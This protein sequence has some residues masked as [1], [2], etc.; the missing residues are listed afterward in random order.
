[1]VE[2]GIP[3]LHALGILALQ[4]GSKPLQDAIKTLSAAINEGASFY[5]A[6]SKAP[7]MFDSTFV[8]LV[9]AGEESGA[10]PE[11]LHMLANHADTSDKTRREIRAAMIYPACVIVC[12]A[13]MSSLLLIFVIPSLKE[14]FSDGDFS[15]PWLT[16]VVMSISDGVIDNGIELCGIACVALLILWR[17]VGTEL[18]KRT[19]RFITF[20]TPYVEKLVKQA[21]AL[22]VI[23]T[24]GIT[25]RVGIPIATALRISAGASGNA[26]VA[27]ELEITRSRVINGS[28][29]SDALSGSLFL[30][31]SVIQMLRVG[32]M[33]GSLDT[34]L[35]TIARHSEGELG[36]ARTVL[37][38]LLEPALIVALGLIIGTLVVATYLPL[39]SMG[40]LF[41][42]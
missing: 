29:L 11:T 33:T 18:G 22:R 2:V 38:N 35:K 37:K 25:L 27:R 23:T 30:A 28:P 8:H 15:L 6:M 34:I 36:Q 31:P 32:E 42:R 24:L 14:I 4:P 39:F 9:Q 41:T 12:A 10:L 13:F 17:F 7:W 1:M 40:N 3:P 19:T 21:I 20:N 5:D 26:F 16:R